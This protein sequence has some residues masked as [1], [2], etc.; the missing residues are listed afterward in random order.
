MEN[1][2]NEKTT[3]IKVNYLARVE[4]EGN[5]YIDI[6][7]GQLKS[8][9]F[10]IHEPPRFFEAFLR[11]RKFSEAPD[12]TSR[13]CGICPIAYQMSSVHA[14]E[15]ALEVKITPWIRKMRRFLYCGEHIQSHILH[16]YLLH[17]PDFLGYESSIHMAKDHPQE[18]E[19]GLQ[20]KKIG[21]EIME[22]IG[23]R[24]VH[25]INV[26]VGGFYSAP[27][28]KAMRDMVP[29][30]DRACD[31]ARA[32]TKWVATLPFPEFE[33][34]Y[35][36]VSLHHPDEYAFNEGQIVSNKGLDITPAQFNATFEEIHVEHSNALHCRFRE[37][38]ACYYNGPLAR[39]ANNFDQLSQ[40]TRDLAREVG[41]D[42]IVSNPFKSILVRCLESF[43][44]CKEAL[45]IARDYEEPDSPSVPVHPQAGEGHAW[46]EAPRGGLYHHYVLDDE[47]NIIKAQLTIPTSQNQAMIEDDLRALVPQY[48]DLPDDQLQ[49]KCEQ[50]IRNY[51]PCISCA[52]HFLNLHVKR[53]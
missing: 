43:E 33:R 41:L 29:M 1:A 7:K 46:T 47:G 35:T 51:D 17:A 45:Q 27:S 32:A 37:T 10:G 25:P 28:K 40:G 4:G 20:L 22:M 49:W 19:H 9:N 11:G 48:I 6:E 3:T 13:I 15:N 14:M 44:Y 36:Y 42:R 39:F 21:N 8:L 26:K 16:A 34:Q 23:G 53:S 50:A 30:L 52:T 5:M 38:G 18:V 31:M 24:A 2:H 12:I